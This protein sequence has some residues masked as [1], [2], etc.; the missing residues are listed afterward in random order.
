MVYISRK[1]YERNG[2]ETIEENYEIFWINEKYIKGVDP[3]N[4]REIIIKYYSM[5]T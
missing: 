5:K 2:I 4:W 1:R 3:T